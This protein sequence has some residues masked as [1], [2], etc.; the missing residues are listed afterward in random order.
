MMVDVD[1]KI[2]AVIPYY[3]ETN[4]FTNESISNPGGV[5]PLTVTGLFARLNIG[6]GTNQFT[7]TPCWTNAVVTNYVINYTSY[8]PNAVATNVCYT[9]EVNQ[10]VNYASAW[11]GT[12]YSWVTASNWPTVVYQETNAATYGEWPWQIYAQ[13]LEERYKV[14]NALEVLN[15]RNF[16]Y[17]GSNY[18]S[19]SEGYGESATW[20]G[21][22]AAAEASM[23][24][25]WVNRA[26]DRQSSTESLLYAG[27]Y[28]AKKYVWMKQGLYGTITNG[29]LASTNINGTVSYYVALSTNR[30]EETGGFPIE[31]VYNANGTPNAD[32]DLYYL[33]TNIP[34]VQGSFDG[35]MDVSTDATWCDEPPANEWRVKGFHHGKWT[36]L[37]YTYYERCFLVPVFQYCTNKYW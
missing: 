25:N 28:S 23:T 16:S 5:I 17:G 14:L 18:I 32:I 6:D 11:D 30:P 8:Y 26:L 10:V 31:S 27:I 24:S 13:D 7:R 9:S 29:N 2:K 33:W 34:L 3:I 37:N 20:A 19:E 36:A 12:N 35:I 1:A 4:C 22:K 21:A 15:F